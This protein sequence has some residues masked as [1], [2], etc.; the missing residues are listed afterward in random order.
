MG[1]YELKGVAE[2]VCVRQ[3]IGQT[4]AESR[5][6]AAHRGSITS[7]VG[8]EHEIGLVLDRWQQAR[9]GYGQIVLLSGEAGIGKSRITETLQERTERDQPIRLLY[10]CS[11]Y[12]TNSALH[13]VI[14]QL[15]HAAGFGVEDDNEVKL[16][17]LS[18]LLSQS[19]QVI[20]DIAPLLATLL[21]I[22]QEGRNVSL[23]MTP[24]RQKE[25]TLEGLV[26][27]LEG[28]SQQRT[29]LLIFEDAHW[30][31][32]TSLEWL[33]LVIARAQRIPVVVVITFRPEFQPPWSGYT[34]VT[35][36]TLNRFSGSLA[37]AQ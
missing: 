27:Q 16:A 21:S 12:H 1:E 2:P 3:V 13:P 22:P 8:R 19:M 10:Q 14:A 20:D 36:L 37:A 32:P 28:L 35:S 15:E 7:L 9:E 4:R 17:K 30:A 24:E 18:S 25:M 5:F 29:V 11:P 26:S 31:D 33:E 34:H 23:G 6:A